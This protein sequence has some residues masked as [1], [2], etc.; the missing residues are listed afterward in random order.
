MAA[1]DVEA[2]REKRAE[3]DGDNDDPLELD[4]DFLASLN[5]DPAT[6]ALMARTK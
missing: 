6:L 1:A 2:M 3:L 4:D 5:L